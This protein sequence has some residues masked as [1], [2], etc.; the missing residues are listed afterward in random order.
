M[1]C[2]V[3]ILQQ[4][5]SDVVLMIGRMES[6][7]QNL[8]VLCSL[9]VV[10]GYSKGGEGCALADR[11]IAEYFE[12]KKLSVKVTTLMV[13]VNDS[14]GHLLI[15]PRDDKPAWKCLSDGAIAL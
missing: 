2:N 6:M 12:L 9:T 8:Q 15:S 3:D 13:H 10:S 1:V 11:Q 14:L 5:Y 4:A 7:D